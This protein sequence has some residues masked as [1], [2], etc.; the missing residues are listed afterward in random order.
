MSGT[1]NEKAYSLQEALRAQ[2]ALRAL[3]GL[4]PELFPVRAFVGMISDE[5]ETLREKGHTDQQIAD[6]IR[7]NSSIAIS[8][9]EVADFYA[10]PE[11][12]HA[13]RH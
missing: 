13:P 1:Q 4:Q 7:N 9:Q 6:T 8:A 5:I 10:P 12:R 11:L 2:Q 3:A